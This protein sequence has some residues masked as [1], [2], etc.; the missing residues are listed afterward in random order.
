[1]KHEVKK[2]RKFKVVKQSLP[3]HLQL[4]KALKP[5]Q[6]HFYSRSL[7]DTLVGHHAVLTLGLSAPEVGCGRS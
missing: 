2:A 3:T 1:M 7:R 5:G 4:G 6:N